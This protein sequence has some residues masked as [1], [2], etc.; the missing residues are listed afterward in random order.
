MKVLI[1]CEESQ[2]VTKAFRE[3]GHEAYSCDI[4]PCSSGHPEWHIQQDVIA[5]LA[6]YW[7]LLIAHPPCT[8]LSY[9]GNIWFKDKYKDRFPNRLEQR[10]K[11]IVFFLE[12]VNAKVNKIAIE[13]PVGVMNSIYRKPDQVISPHQFGHDFSKRTCLWLKNLPKIT[14][15]NIISS[16]LPFQTWELHNGAMVSMTPKERSTFRS[17]T[18]QGIANAMAEQWG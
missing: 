10:D 3:R 12:F 5:I 15:T 13:N 4:L 7:D 18:A 8:Y 17:K 1:A 2:I 14:P 9:V 11:A 6:N 16:P